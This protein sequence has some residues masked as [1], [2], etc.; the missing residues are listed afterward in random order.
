[1]TEL[2]HYDEAQPSETLARAEAVLAG[3]GAGDMRETA[4][5]AAWFAAKL[6]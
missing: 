6:P 1:V 4:M 3:K 2:F 5:A